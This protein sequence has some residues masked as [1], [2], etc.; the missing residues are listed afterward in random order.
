MGQG[1]QDTGS[2]RGARGTS[3]WDTVC[4]DRLTE[5]LGPGMAAKSTAWEWEL[6]KRSLDPL[7][8]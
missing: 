8:C 7:N 4:E 2:Y 6:S 1:Q 3:R 5:D